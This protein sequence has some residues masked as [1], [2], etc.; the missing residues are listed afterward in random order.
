M[1]L[2]WVNSEGRGRPEEVEPGGGQGLGV[3]NPPY[4]CLG[5]GP[6]PRRGFREFECGSASQVGPDQRL[7]CEPA[8]L[9]SLELHL[10]WAGQAALAANL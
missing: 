1:W 5:G 6:R 4:S 7:G 2:R 10:T 9:V 8:G 3:Q